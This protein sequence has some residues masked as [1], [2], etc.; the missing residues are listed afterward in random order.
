[1]ATLAE[2]KVLIGADVSSFDRKITGVQKDLTRVGNKMKSI[3]KT[4]S[5][6]VTAPLALLAGGAIKSASSLETMEVAFESMLGSGEAAS[7]MV[8]DLTEFTAKTPFQLEGVGKAAK[9]LLSFG[10]AGDEIQ[11]KLKFLGDIASGA[12]VPLSDMASIFGKAKAKGKAMTEELLQLSDRGV[13]II[14]TLATQLGVAKDEIFDLASKGKISFEKLQRA[15]VS[16][17]DQ[18]GIF[19]DQMVK[20]SGTIAGVWSTLKDNVELALGELGGEIVEA[21]DLK[22]VMSDTIEFVQGVIT[23]FKN[24]SP[25][26]K[27]TIVVV[28]AVVAAAG[29]MIAALGFLAST[30]LPA[31][32]T[33]LG[34]LL[35]PIG[36]VV[37][38][39]AALGFAAFSVVKHFEK[40]ASAQE[41][42]ND[43]YK[44]AKK[45]ISGEVAELDKL[46]T[47]AKSEN[48]SRKKRQ[49]ALDT[50]Q[51]KYPKYLKNVTLEGINSGT[52]AKKLQ[53][54]KR[55]LLQVATARAIQAKLQ[56]VA[57]KKLEIETGALE[58]NIDAIDV[59]I[60]AVK[61][62][63]GFQSLQTSAT[64]LA[65]KA[66]DNQK[67]SMAGLD[68][69]S[70]LLIEKLS[71]L[72]KQG[73]DTSEAMDSIVPDDGGGGIKPLIDNVDKARVSF[74]AFA[75][76]ALK[77]VDA[78]FLGIGTLKGTAIKPMVKDLGFARDMARQWSA[79]LGESPI[80]TLERQ[81]DLIK[82]GIDAA[83]AAPGPI[84]A[85]TKAQI[86]LYDELNNKIIAL[87]EAQATLGR[88]SQLIAGNISSLAGSIGEAIGE[89]LASGDATTAFRGFV[90][91][92]LGLVKAFGSIL[93][94]IGTGLTASVFGIVEG[95]KTIAAGIALV[96]A[97]TAG[98]AMF[99]QGG[100]V[101]G[102][103]MGMVGEG[104]GTSK[105]NPEVIAPLD[106]L[107]SMLGGGGQ[108]ITIDWVLEGDK[109]RAVQQNTSINS[110]FISPTP[111]FNT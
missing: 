86:Q 100:L 47:I 78:V 14:D 90:K 102:P 26:M 39:I 50:I 48:L 108:N 41:V 74:N 91:D 93:I 101:S 8:K 3:G 52:T 28:G 16:M 21:F 107:Q 104:R 32:I 103:V 98:M 45:S 76:D 89:G 5:I 25:A 73:V 33:G 111:N 87:S 6:G 71:Q 61:S 106:K 10:V 15:M 37:A 96:A 22:A 84:K 12:N 68:A 36:L 81:R 85:A 66:M 70:A 72:E 4:L 82:E 1:M 19:E 40:M 75:Q 57:A 77:G 65:S 17:T 105:S 29:P 92:M 60:A 34:V 53:E 54:L 62:L 11:D 13:P 23:K 63:Y 38:G 9:Q 43:T 24:L 20:Q 7:A 67:A 97:S 94:A 2:L 56:E 95:P 44:E 42:L 35:G 30:V 51:K 88:E 79:A 109:L 64:D 55:S 110:E 49:E 46:V 80:E 18:G 27:K 31:L 83:Q 99:A 69:Q 59:G 58:D